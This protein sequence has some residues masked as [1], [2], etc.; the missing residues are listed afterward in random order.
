MV[1]VTIQYTNGRTIT[2]TAKEVFYK[3]EFGWLQEIGYL[4]ARKNRRKWFPI[5]G[6]RDDNNDY[7]GT[8]LTVK[9]TL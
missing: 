7:S 1:N 4:P 9:E 8:I 3:T 5:G 2:F 6:K